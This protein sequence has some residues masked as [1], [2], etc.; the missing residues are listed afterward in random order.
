MVPFF[1]SLL[2]DLGRVEPVFH[3]GKMSMASTCLVLARKSIKKLLGF[4]LLMLS[5]VVMLLQVLQ[6][7][8]LVF[9]IGV[10]MSTLILQLLYVLCKLW[11]VIM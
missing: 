8:R 10:F 11:L 4:Q 1:F 3:S 9:L 5:I 6:F 2:L 7:Y